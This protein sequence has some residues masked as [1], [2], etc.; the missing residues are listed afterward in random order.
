MALGDF[1]EALSGS[2]D[3]FAEI[4]MGLKGQITSWPSVTPPK[5]SPTQL[6]GAYLDLVKEEQKATTDQALLNILAD[7]EE[8][9][10]QTLYKLRFLK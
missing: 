4:Y 8:L 6:L 9:V 3:S 2:V 1:Y 7:I 10:A 5:G